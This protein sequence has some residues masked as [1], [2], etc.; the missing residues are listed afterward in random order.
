MIDANVLRHGQHSAQT[1]GEL[2]HRAFWIIG[3]HVY[4]RLRGWC[5]TV[6]HG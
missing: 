2:I 5:L 4:D 3:A 6:C 1:S